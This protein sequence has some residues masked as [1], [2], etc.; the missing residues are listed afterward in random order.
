M[1]RSRRYAQDTSVAVAKSRGDI[2]RLLDDFGADG[3]QWT[4]SRKEGKVT[5]QFLWTDSVSEE[6]FLA[7][8]SIILPD[9]AVL[10]EESVDGRSGRFSQ[11]KYDKAREAMGRREHR[12]LFL[13]LKACLVAI[14]EGIVQP[15]DV[16]LPFLV[17]PSGKTVA[18]M[19]R[20]KLKAVVNDVAGLLTAG[21]R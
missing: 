17:T 1:A 13:W 10:R 15:E 16:F 12:A 2:E 11:S 7:R 6:S 5:L 20:G 14:E 9:D 21:A 4:D 8:F 19:A 18:E 3:W